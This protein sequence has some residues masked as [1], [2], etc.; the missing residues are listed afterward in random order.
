MPYT[1]CCCLGWYYKLWSVTPALEAFVGAVIWT[2]WVGLLCLPASK[3]FAWLNFSFSSVSVRWLRNEG[4]YCV[5]KKWVLKVCIGILFF[6]FF[7]TKDSFAVD[8][9]TQAKNKSIHWTWGSPPLVDVK[10]YLVISFFKSKNIQ[11][12]LPSTED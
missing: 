4:C 12:P 8:S 9:W 3:R 6:F 7:S 1:L 5:E 10:G 2:A 11:Y